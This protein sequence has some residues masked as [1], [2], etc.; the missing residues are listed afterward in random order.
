MSR[1][2]ATTSSPIAAAIFACFSESFPSVAETCDCSSWLKSYGSAP[3]WRT[4]ARSFA[5]PYLPMFVIWP[6][7]EMPFDRLGS[8]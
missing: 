5:S 1:K 3:V 8:V 4:I 6:P 7:P 2:S